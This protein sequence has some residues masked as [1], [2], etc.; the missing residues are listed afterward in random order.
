MLS[1]DKPWKRGPLQVWSL[2]FSYAV[3]NGGYIIAFPIEPC[4]LLNKTHINNCIF[5]ILKGSKEKDL[6]CIL[7]PCNQRSS[8]ESHLPY[9]TPILVWNP[10]NKIQL[11][12]IKWKTMQRFN[13]THE[14]P[15]YC[16]YKTAPKK[17]AQTKQE[18]QISTSSAGVSQSNYNLSGKFHRL[19]AARRCANKVLYPEFTSTSI[20]RVFI[21]SIAWESIYWYFLKWRN[22]SLNSLMWGL[23]GGSREFFFRNVLGNFKWNMTKSGEFSVY[24]SGWLIISNLS[25]TFHSLIYK[26]DKRYKKIYKANQ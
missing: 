19:L 10:N 3:D 11:N 9:S 23:R 2:N 12:V 26:K 16:R 5:L 15:W 25:I 1:L 13:K 7:E 6:L 22:K 4:W 24:G 21:D 14:F 17:K 18:L 20:A 8:S